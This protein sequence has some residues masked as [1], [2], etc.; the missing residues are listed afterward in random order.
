[1]A[2]AH[3]KRFLSTII[4]IL[5]KAVS[6]NRRL[7]YG[8]AHAQ[9]SDLFLGDSNVEVT[10]DVEIAFLAFWLLMHIQ[11][12]RRKDDFEYDSLTT[13]TASAAAA[14]PTDSAVRVHVVSGER[15]NGAVISEHTNIQVVNARGTLIQLHEPVLFGQPL[16]MK[17]LATNEETNCTVVDVN[18]GS[19]EVPEIGVAFDKPSPGFW[20]V[21]CPPVDWTP[22]NREAKRAPMHVLVKSP[23]VKK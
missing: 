6:S 15:A 13:A 1:M 5:S 2:Q 19:T 18:Q 20:P 10:T 16:R 4:L 22:R 21:S 11:N 14:Q 3:R 17:N 8:G 7:K 23:V 12:D 9:P